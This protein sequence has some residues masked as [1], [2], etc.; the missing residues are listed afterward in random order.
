MEYLILSRNLN[1][2]N[3]FQPILLTR[4]LKSYSIESKKRKRVVFGF[5]SIFSKAFL[6]A[7]AIISRS[8]R[9]PDLHGA[10]HRTS[11]PYHL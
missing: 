8:N 4:A 1:L 5:Y 2:S 6:V 9:P 10:R 3:N 11:I 7:R